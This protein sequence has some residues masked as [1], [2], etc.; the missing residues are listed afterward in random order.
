MGRLGSEKGFDV[1]INAFGAIAH[2][3]PDWELVIYGE[4]AE[5][6]NL[7][8]LIRTKGLESRIR[9]P[10]KTDNP[11]QQLANADIFVLSSRY[12]GFPN[13]LLEALASNLCVVATD[14]SPSVHEILQQGEFGLVCET[15]NE[16]D[17]QR[18]LSKAIE[19]PELRAQYSSSARNAVARY[20]IDR[21]GAVW[22]QLIG[23]L[24]E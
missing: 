3:N 8:N 19:D 15:E 1:L 12:E 5:R 2:R 23:E 16:T 20:D 24:A 7:E 10:G 9:L 18:Q 17:L 6:Q 4:G 22:T 14:C 21:V 11:A 13:V